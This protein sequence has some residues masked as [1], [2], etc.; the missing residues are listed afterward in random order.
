MGGELFS[1]YW[2]GGVLKDLWVY[3]KRTTAYPLAIDL[4]I[5][6]AKY[7]P[8]ETS[9]K[10]YPFTEPSQNQ[11]PGDLHQVQAQMRPLILGGSMWSI[12]EAYLSQKT[13]PLT[14]GERQRFGCKLTSVLILAPSS[15]S[16]E[17]YMILRAQWAAETTF[18]H[19]SIHAGLHWLGTYC[20]PVYHALF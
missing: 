4:H 12:R 17:Y 10:S 18:V 1:I 8:P 20:M 11:G 6:C 16:E 7:S 15:P 13:I 2:R 3:L 5:S 19:N 14:M 9:W